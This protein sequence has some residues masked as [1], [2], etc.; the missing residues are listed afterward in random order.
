M[1]EESG[2]TPFR[3]C[4]LLSAIELFTVTNHKPFND[5][6]RP[7]STHSSVHQLLRPERCVGLLGSED[8]S[9]ALWSWG[10]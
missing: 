5:Q 1:C 6:V 8:R 7:P 3:H 4:V 2:F 10:F 9:T